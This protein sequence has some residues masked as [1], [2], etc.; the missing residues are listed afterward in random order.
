M[1]LDKIRTILAKY[2]AT[3]DC[4]SPDGNR[5]LVRMQSGKAIWLSHAFTYFDWV[6]GYIME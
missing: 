6:P 2:N 1:E 5:I 4:V 3:L